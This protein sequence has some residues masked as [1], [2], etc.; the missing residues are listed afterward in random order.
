MVNL[1]GDKLFVYFCNNLC[2]VITTREYRGTERSNS[3]QVAQQIQSRSVN[4]VIQ[5]HWPHYLVICKNQK[6][7]LYS[8]CYNYTIDSHISVFILKS[9]IFFLNYEEAISELIIESKCFSSRLGNRSVNSQEK[10]SSQLFTQ[11][12]F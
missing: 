4:F 3:L 1:N 10:P 12:L 7:N 8:L 9:F 2:I 11:T 6:S 5:I